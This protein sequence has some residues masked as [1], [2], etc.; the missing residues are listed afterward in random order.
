MNIEQIIALASVL[1]LSL[2]A[3]AHG[4]QA[5]G[6]SVQAWAA[7]TPSKDDD[8]WA[9]KLVRFANGLAFVVELAGSIVPRLTIGSTRR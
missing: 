2:T 5:L 7:T 6:R 3:F 4:L 1:A 9:G 8:R